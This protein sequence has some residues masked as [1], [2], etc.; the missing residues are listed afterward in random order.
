MVFVG[1]RGSRGTSPS[2]DLPFPPTG[3]SENLGEW[4]GGGEGKGRV[5][6]PPA[7]LPPLVSASNTTLSSSS[8]YVVVL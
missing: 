7:L 4:K 8:I 1:G 6:R 5:V 3:L 2:L